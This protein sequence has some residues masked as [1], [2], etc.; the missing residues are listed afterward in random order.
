M[1]TTLLGCIYFYS[2]LSQV[3]PQITL[4]VIE[5]ESNGNPFALSPDRKDGGLMQVRMKYAPESPAQL[6]QSCTNVKRGTELLKQAMNK[7]IHK[8]DNTWVIC[9]NTG[10]RGG[11]KIKHPKKFPYFLKITARL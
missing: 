5:T 2:F 4:A 8:L 10:L 9:F 3:N 6:F 7:C 11:A 1:G